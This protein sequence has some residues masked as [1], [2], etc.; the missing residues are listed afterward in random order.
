MG[1]SGRIDVIL[2]FEIRDSDDDPLITKTETVAV[3]TQANFVRTFTIPSDAELGK[4]SL[5]VKLTYADGKE[6]AAES[7]F[8]IVNKITAISRTVYYILGGIILLAGLIYLGMKSKTV[9]EKLKMK[10]QIRCIVKH[11][12][13]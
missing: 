1:S 11:R 5:K 12:L 10:N 7:S 4:Y 8:E 6:A 9:V 13:N 2:N 3:E